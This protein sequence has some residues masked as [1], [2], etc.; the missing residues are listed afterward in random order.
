MRRARVCL[1][2]PD[3]PIRS[4]GT[5]VTVA[6]RACSVNSR[7]PGET[8]DLAVPAPKRRIASPPRTPVRLSG[9]DAAETTPAAAT[10]VIRPRISITRLGPSVR[11]GKNSTSQKRCESR[12]GRTRRIRAVW[13]SSTSGGGVRACSRMFSRESSAVVGR[14]RRQTSDRAAEASSPVRFSQAPLANNT[15]R[16]RSRTK[17][18]SLERRK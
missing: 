13:P 16:R 15:R 17:M 18:G 14:L 1:P 8:L 5:A 6:R 2:V 11:R 3:S 9:N 4:T 12:P 10:D 7:S